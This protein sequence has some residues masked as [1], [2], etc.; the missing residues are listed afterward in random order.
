[1]KILF[2][3]LSLILVLNL[4]SSES[5]GPIDIDD[6]NFLFINGSIPNHVLIRLDETQSLWDTPEFKLDRP[7]I[8]YAFDFLENHE[9]VST[10][11][12][13][14]AYLQRGDHNILILDY[15][16]LSGGN[17]IFDAVPNAMKVRKTIIN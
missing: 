5:C 13:V 4:V 1:M 9:S 3:A 7:T 15:G 6:V 16:E 17:Y 11:S 8:I 2:K 10:Q 12:I 14:D